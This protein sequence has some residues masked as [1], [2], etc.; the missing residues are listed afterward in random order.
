MKFERNEILTGLLVFTTIGV[1]IAVILALAA[2]GLFRPLDSYQVF[3]DNAAGVKPGAPVLVAGRK[4]GQVSAID[5]PVPKAKRPAKY[6]EYEVLLTV[7]IDRKATV[8]R[9]ATARMQQNG[10]LGEQVIDFV[11]GTEDT[12]KAE[13]GYK[14][15]GYRVPDLNSALP[16]ILTIIEPVAST[17]TLALSD[18][19]KTIENLN[20]VFSQESDLRGALTKL[21][22]TADNL[23]IVTAP[24]GT[25]GHSLQNLEGITAK[26]KDDNGPLMGMLVNLERTTDQISKDN[27]LE[28][29][30][31]NFQT[32]SQRADATIK[33]A[34]ALI[35]SLTPA[36]HQSASNFEQMT[37]TLK[38]QP[39]RL[40]WPSTKKYDPTVTVTKVPAAQGG[41][42]TLITRQRKTTEEDESPR[43]RRPLKERQ[44][45]LN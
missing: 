12:G 8:F 31:T 9:N 19:R 2:P 13:S 30:L 4:I 21:R 32:A 24:D 26:L 7:R 14:F 34:N 10:L 35:A 22:L 45:T 5:S 28:K 37:D 3:F 43:R 39:W 33:Q 25:L 23:S 17:A 20:T 18:L 11:G 29:M 1:L 36:L 15:V 41:P 27:R 6:P 38:R 16:K 40:V 44:R 42:E